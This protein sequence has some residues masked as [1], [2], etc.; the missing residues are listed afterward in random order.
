M[1]SRWAVA[2]SLGLLLGAGCASS[3]VVRLETS[4]GQPMEYSSPSW[5]KSVHLVADDFEQALTLLVLEIPLTLRPAHP[6]QLVLASYPSNHADSR[7]QFLMSQSFGGIC[8]PGQRR[9]DCLSLLDDVAG[10][11]EWDKLGV[12]LGLSIEPMK[13]SISRAVENTLAPQL[14]Y[15]VIATGL[16]SWALL[17][18]NPEPVFTKAAAI[19]SAVM[20]IYL[21]VETFLEAVDAARELKGAT[22]R[23]TTFE[24]LDAAGKRFA[25]RVGPEV[26]RVFVLAVTI[27]VTQ[28]MNGGASWLASRLSTLPRFSEAASLGASQVAIKLSGVGQAT[29]WSSTTR[30]RSRR[31]EPMRSTTWPSSPER[32]TALAPTTS[33]TTPTCHDLR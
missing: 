2:M 13:Q 32:I 3:R 25:N 28:G 1:T 31:E 33:R 26:A 24:E 21:G 18:A 4:Q 27:V 5:N 6:G 20:L 30:C 16:I 7:W 17:A 9:T 14:F 15:T 8:K 12:A 10:L 23:A 11:T 22:D 19:V 29:R